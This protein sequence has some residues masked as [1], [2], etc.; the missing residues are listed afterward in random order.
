MITIKSEAE[1]QNIKRAAQVVA[2]ML[3]TI[4]AKVKPG[5][6]K[7]DLDKIAEQVLN[8]NNAQTSFKG[9]G[10]FPNHIC[11]SINNELIH[12]I[13]N[14]KI[15]NNGDLVS[16]DA[17]AVINGYHAD[18]AITFGIGEIKPEYK[19]LIDVT[20]IALDKAIEVIKAGVQ[21][22]TIGATI[23]KYVENEGYYLPKNY[24]G[25]GIGLQLHEDPYIPNYG[26]A[27]TGPFLQTGMTIC[28]EPMV[29][30]NTD[31]TRVLDD[32]WT[33]VSSDG[34]FSAHFEHTILVTE[35]GCQ[36][37]SVLDNLKDVK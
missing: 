11:V 7:S 28:I 18:S 3:H 30:I 14:D 8:E 10:G 13:A 12:G 25:H 19:K 2:L 21:I 22:G 5:M 24:T 36:V 16:I 9:Y 32:D 27:N 31:Q 23:Q 15:I 33:V 29:Q 4:K 1:I 17:G 35:N 26:I 37:L 20:K 6:K 34:S